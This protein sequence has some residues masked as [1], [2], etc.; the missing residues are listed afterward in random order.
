MEKIF[1]TVGVYPNGSYKVN[2]VKGEN[3]IDHINYNKTYR[4]GRALFVEGVCHHKGS[5]TEREVM[6]WSGRIMRDK[7][8]FWR[9][10]DTQPYK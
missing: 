8:I 2:G 4:P 10:V 3:L 9:D 6:D 1:S 7:E 5:L